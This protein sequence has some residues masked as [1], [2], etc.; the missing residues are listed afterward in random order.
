MQEQKESVITEQSDHECGRAALRC[1]G[2][3]LNGGALCTPY[4]QPGSVKFKG[5]FCETCLKDGII[6]PSSRIRALSPEQAKQA[7][8]KHSGGFWNQAPQSLG[9]RLFRTINNTALCAGS[10][11]AIFRDEPP[12]LD[13]PDLPDHWAPQPR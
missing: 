10:W 9:G 11:L 3:S 4:F 12:A 13:F 8:N 2:A 7:T 1:W 5:K 6:V